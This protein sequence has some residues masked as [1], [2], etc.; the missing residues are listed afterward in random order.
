[1]NH[2]VMIVDDDA[3]VLN[4]VKRILESDGI[5]V[6][7]ASSGRA[8]ID[9]LQD[10]FRGL[11][12]MDIAMPDMD[13]W[14]TIEEIVEKG[15]NQDVIFIMLTGKDI[16]DPKMDHLKEYVLDYITKPFHQNK[17]ISVVKEYLSYL[18]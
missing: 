16:P 5:E 7:K 15:L 2:A 14:E 1:M 12:L 8:C 10:G 9:S 13:G 18:D 3:S 6:H 11:V 17:L 4:V